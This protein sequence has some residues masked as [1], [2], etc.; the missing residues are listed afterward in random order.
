MQ[1]TASRTE[2]RKPSVLKHLQGTRR[3]SPYQTE[4]P[5]HSSGHNSSLTAGPS[6]RAHFSASPERR[7]PLHP[8]GRARLSPA[9][10]GCA[11]RGEQRTAELL[12]PALRAATFLNPLLALSRAPWGLGKQKGPR[13]LAGQGRAP[14]LTRCD[15]EPL[16]RPHTGATHVSLWLGGSCAARGLR[17]GHQEKATGLP[18]RPRTRICRPLWGAPSEGQASTRWDQRTRRARAAPFQVHPSVTPEGPSPGAVRPE[19]PGARGRHALLSFK[20][21]QTSLLSSS[22]LLGAT[23]WGLF[24]S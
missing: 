14:A 20:G 10:R 1:T 22:Q 5:G 3:A 9:V 19:Q 4:A 7:F 18:C 11:V 24:M 17:L 23:P 15:A 12:A 13:G 6:P 2:M 8:E 21:E 16:W